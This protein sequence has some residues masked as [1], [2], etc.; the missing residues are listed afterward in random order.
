[1]VEHNTL[2]RKDARKKYARLIK[3]GWVEQP[4]DDSSYV[5]VPAA[6]PAAPTVGT[7]PMETGSP[8]VNQIQA[9]AGRYMILE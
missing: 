1:M 8:L 6:Q 9:Y 3:G 5:L 2:S 7:T 4:T